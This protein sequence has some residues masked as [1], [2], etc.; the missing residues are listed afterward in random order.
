MAHFT[1]TL[2]ENEIF[3]SAECV[4]WATLEPGYRRIISGFCDTSGTVCSTSGILWVT[5]LYH[6]ICISR[7]LSSWHRLARWL[8]CHQWNVV[9][10]GLCHQVWSVDMT[11]ER[12]CGV[13]VIGKLGLWF[14]ICGWPHR[15]LSSDAVSPLCKLTA[16]WPCP[17][18]ELVQRGCELARK[19]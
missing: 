5:Q 2:M 8:C 10:E 14:I 18:M 6:A 11:A 12:L 15:H 3:Q 1:T 19:V 17:C 16:H 9:V 4:S 13:A 7:V